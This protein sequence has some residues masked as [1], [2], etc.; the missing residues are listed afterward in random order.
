MQSFA[1][2]FFIWSDLVYRALVGCK[3]AA[4]KLFFY[5]FFLLLFFFFLIINHQGAC[6]KIDH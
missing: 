3:Q 4:V 6:S 2:L 5:H 1:M